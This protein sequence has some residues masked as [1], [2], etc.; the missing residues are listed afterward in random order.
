MFEKGKLY[1]VLMNFFCFFQV[2]I[3]S[4]MPFNMRDFGI[5]LHK[6]IFTEKYF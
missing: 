4:C 6:N 1:S 5:F 3:S 2:K